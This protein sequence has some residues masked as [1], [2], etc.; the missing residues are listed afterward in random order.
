MVSGIEFTKFSDE[1][2]THLIAP[3]SEEEV[4]EAVWDCDRNKSPGSDGFNLNFFK[5]FLDIVKKD[6]LCFF[7]RNFIAHRCC[8]KPSRH[9]FLH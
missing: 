1:Q 2:Y 8:R 3:F 7:L 6:I 9:L 4:K 5:V